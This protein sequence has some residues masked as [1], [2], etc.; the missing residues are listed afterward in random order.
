MR[1]GGGGGAQSEKISL[2]KRLAQVRREDG[3]GGGN[4]SQLSRGIKS[5]RKCRWV[6]NTGKIPKKIEMTQSG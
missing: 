4:A 5:L 6:L 2:S 1:P 3:G